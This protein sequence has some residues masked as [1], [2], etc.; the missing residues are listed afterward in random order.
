MVV[1]FGWSLFVICCALFNTCRCE[2]LL[3]VGDVCCSCM[4]LLFVG[5]VVCCS[6]FAVCCLLF[7]GCCFG[8]SCLL[9]VS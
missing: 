5:V 6:L 4:F 7:V 1:V 9:F 3:L 8:V 2:G